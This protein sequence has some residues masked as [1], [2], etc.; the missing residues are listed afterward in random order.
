M[1]KTTLLLRHAD[2]GTKIGIF[3]PATANF[4]LR[5]TLTS[6]LDLDGVKL[7]HH[8]NKLCLALVWHFND[9]FLSPALETG[10]LQKEVK[11]EI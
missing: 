4:H 6:E 7:D 3:T 5:R 11:Y 2:T 8:Q 10:R 9:N 1:P